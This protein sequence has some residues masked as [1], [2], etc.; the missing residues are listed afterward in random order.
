MSI[1][2]LRRSL[3]GAAAGVAILIGGVWT[4]RLAAG[5]IGHGR[6]FDAE[7]IFGRIADRLD[8]SESQRDQVK[9]VLRTRKDAIVGEIEAVRTAR[10]ALRQ[11][12]EAQPFDESAVRARAADLGKAQGDAAVLHAEIRGQILTILNDEQKEK[13]AALRRGAESTDHTVSSVRDFLSK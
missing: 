6:H 7:R 5:P 3:L 2:T 8:L 10:L 4:G 11:A 12:I 9:D 13:L 1:Q